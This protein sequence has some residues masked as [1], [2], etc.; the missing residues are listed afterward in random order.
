MFDAV[1]T[2]KAT[3]ERLKRFRLFTAE[4]VGPDVEVDA[5]FVDEV[6]LASQY[7]LIQLSLVVYA[8]GEVSLGKYLKK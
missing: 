2:E 6:E 4:M 1:P 8:L 7:Q 5:R 3:P